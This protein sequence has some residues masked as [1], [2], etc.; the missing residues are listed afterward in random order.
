MIENLTESSGFGFGSDN[1]A[2]NFDGKM[3][4]TIN[5]GDQVV[6]YLKL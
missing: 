1:F 6:L 3:W 5:F 2:V 4:I